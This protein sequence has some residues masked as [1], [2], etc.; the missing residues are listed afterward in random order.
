MSP[1]ADK[2]IK[3]EMDAALVGRYAWRCTHAKYRVAEAMIDGVTELV[4]AKTANVTLPALIRH[5]MLGTFIEPPIEEFRAAV[6]LIF[7]RVVERAVERGDLIP[8]VSA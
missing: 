7:A 2:M 4:T 1:E 5:A 3:E 6:R 8:M